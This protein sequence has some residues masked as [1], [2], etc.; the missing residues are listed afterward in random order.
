M[1][2]AYPTW[3][4]A[5]DTHL[6]KLQCLQNKVFRAIGNLDRCTPVCKLLVAFKIPYVYDCITKLCRTQA[7]VIQTHVNPNVSGIQ[8][9]EARHRKY[10][11]LN[12][13]GGQAYD[14]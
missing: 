5:V 2:Y 3:E 4:Y 7:E 9:G 13:G 10:K 6:L 8:Q 12:L 11:R 1:T 14:C